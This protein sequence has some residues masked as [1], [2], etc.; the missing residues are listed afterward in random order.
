[1]TQIVIYINPFYNGNIKCM[2]KMKFAHG[3]EGN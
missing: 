3:C 1:M 2:G